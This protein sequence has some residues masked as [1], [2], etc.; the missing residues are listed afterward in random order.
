MMVVGLIRFICY[1]VNYLYC[2]KEDM[3][4]RRLKVINFDNYLKD[5]LYKCI[6]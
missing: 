6:R 5:Y 4:V 3:N 1:V 2:L